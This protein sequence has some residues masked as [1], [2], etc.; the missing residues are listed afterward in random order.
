MRATTALNDRGRGRRAARNIAR[1]T[2]SGL[3]LALGATGVVGSPACDSGD[4]CVG[5]ISTPC[6]KLPS[7]WCAKARGCQVV[8]GRCVPSCEQNLAEGACTLPCQWSNNKCNSPCA[9]ASD[10][11]KCRSYV[12]SAPGLQSPPVAECEW[13]GSTCTSPCSSANAEEACNA[14]NVSSCAWLACSGSPTGSCSSYSGDECP[15]FLGCEVKT[16]PWLSL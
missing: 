2:L 13:T 3:L 14:M 9:V 10:E 1:A 4:T 8:P 12:A 15:G 5:S 16:N 7:D 11:A 6:N